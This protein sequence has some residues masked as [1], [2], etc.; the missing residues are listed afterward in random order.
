[1]DNEVI[2][3]LE[4]K[5]FDKKESIE[6]QSPVEEKEISTPKDKIVK[7]ENKPLK[8]ILKKEVKKEEIKS[9]GNYYNILGFNLSPTTIYLFIAF[10][11]CIIGYFVWEYYN[12]KK[13]DED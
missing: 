13:E 11:I 4:S 10:I 5:F 3:E 9:E 12:K 8:P 1:M 2:E 6:Q 7:F